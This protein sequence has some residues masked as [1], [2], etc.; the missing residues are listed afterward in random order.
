MMIVTIIII[1]IIWTIVIMIVII[2]IIFITITIFETTYSKTI[3]ENNIVQIEPQP[4]A[5]V[6]NNLSQYSRR[7]K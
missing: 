5:I 7:I 3:L 2:I 4:A 1:A 6:F